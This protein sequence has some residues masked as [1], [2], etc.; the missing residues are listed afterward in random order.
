MLGAIYSSVTGDKRIE[1]LTAGASKA[2]D[3]QAYY[4]LLVPFVASGFTRLAEKTDSA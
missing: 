4:N 2:K 3:Y 1:I